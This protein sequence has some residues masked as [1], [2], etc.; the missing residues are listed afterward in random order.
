M[1]DAEVATLDADNRA[2]HACGES[3]GHDRFHAKGDD[4]VPSLRCHRRKPAD[5]DAQTAEVRESTERI[6]HQH[7][8]AQ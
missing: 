8:A 5:Q 1:N 2:G 4:V 6:R 3:A 7:A